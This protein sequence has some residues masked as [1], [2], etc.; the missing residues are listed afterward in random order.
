MQG[1][2]CEWFWRRGTLAETVREGPRGREDRGNGNGDGGIDHRR[3]HQQPDR[4]VPLCADTAEVYSSA[5]TT[6]CRRDAGPAARVRI[7]IF[8]AAALP[9]G[10]ATWHIPRCVIKG[11]CGDGYKGSERKE[12]GKAHSQQATSPTKLARCP[13]HPFGGKYSMLPQDANSLNCSL[14]CKRY[15]PR[16]AIAV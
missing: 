3:Q 1:R 4:H 11:L 6:T 12:R 5:V 13:E 2:L 10:L 15:R 9:F 16:L 8:A 7:T 14:N